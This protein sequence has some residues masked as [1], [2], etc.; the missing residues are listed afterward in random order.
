[1]MKIRWV[2]DEEKEIPYVGI[3]RPNGVYAVETD[4]ALSLI[5]QGQ[6]EKYKKPKTKKAAG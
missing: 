3:M 6:A 1:M 5:E 4:L 2:D